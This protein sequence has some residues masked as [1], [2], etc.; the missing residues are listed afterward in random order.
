MLLARNSSTV[1]GCAA[2]GISIIHREFDS[3]PL[4]SSK[5][6]SHIS[7]VSFFSSCPVQ[8]WLFWENKSI[9]VIYNF[10]PYDLHQANH[11]VGNRVMVIGINHSQGLRKLPY[12]VLLSNGSSRKAQ[13]SKSS[14]VIEY[15]LDNETF[16]RYVP[17]GNPT[18]HDHPCFDFCTSCYIAKRQNL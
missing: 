18:L 1:V 2:L 3:F 4:H 12:Q 10:P 7:P 9:L 13:C 16:L 8:E 17:Y 6:C 14:F 5:A 11:F 15:A